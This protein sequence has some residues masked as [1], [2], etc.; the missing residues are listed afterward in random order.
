MPAKLLLVR[1]GKRGWKDS[2]SLSCVSIV[3][4]EELL[5]DRD[6]ATDDKKVSTVP[7]LLGVRRCNL[8]AIRVVDVDMNGYECMIVL[9]EG[10]NVTYCVDTLVLLQQ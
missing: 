5:L 4:F 6:G 1:V 2:I 10:S 8:V 3:L 7:S 9:L